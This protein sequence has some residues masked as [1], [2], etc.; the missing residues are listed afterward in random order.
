V[1]AI[2]N[3]NLCYRNKKTAQEKQR[4]VLAWKQQSEHTGS[5]K[6]GQSEGRYERFASAAESDE[7][8]VQ[9]VVVITINGTV[10]Y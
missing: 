6:A 5:N 9:H 7:T 10:G 8:L 2:D 4:D 3:K 1:D